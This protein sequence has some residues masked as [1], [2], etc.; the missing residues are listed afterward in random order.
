VLGRLRIFGAY[1][2]AVLLYVAWLGLR[3]GRMAGSIGGFSLGLLMDAVTGMWGLHMFVKTLVGFLVG[4]FP[5]NE[6]E[7]LLIQPQQAL[8]GA[9][10]IA[11]V[12]NGLFVTLLAL[13][14]GAR[15]TFMVLA[16]WLGSAAYTA[17]V[18]TL[19]S[20]FATR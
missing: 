9:L 2:D 13:D 3:H 4:L 10:V 15:N 17:F 11:L 7:T 1:P 6:R 20:L 16:L 14:T 19:V 8:I 12:H 18:G 5:A